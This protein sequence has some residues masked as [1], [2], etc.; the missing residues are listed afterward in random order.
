MYESLLPA[1][2]WPQHSITFPDRQVLVRLGQWFSKSATLT[3][4]ASRNSSQS[5]KA[6]RRFQS[7]S[8]A[9]EGPCASSF[10]TFHIS[11]PTGVLG[12]LRIRDVP[13]KDLAGLLRFETMRVWSKMPIISCVCYNVH[14][15]VYFPCDKWLSCHV[16]FW[17][18]ASLPTFL[19]ISLR[20]FLKLFKQSHLP[21]VWMLRSHVIYV[22]R[23]SLFDSIWMWP[24]PHFIAVNTLKHVAVTAR[25]TMSS[26][27]A[28]PC[29][30]RPEQI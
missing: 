16:S 8:P 26:P 29:T 17:I 19:A 11:C 28:A 7:S 5:R 12:C 30:W 3:E 22:Y 13:G 20:Y 27:R 15:T 4:D 9:L 24:L 25:S 1:E 18:F 21:C 14:Q 10:D 2:L 6:S 23:T